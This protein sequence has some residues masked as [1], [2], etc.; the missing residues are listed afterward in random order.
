M[1]QL[2]IDIHAVHA[3][4]RLYEIAASAKALDATRGLEPARLDCRTS[5]RSQSRRA[6]SP[7]E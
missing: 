3:V 5:G 2:A 6:D 4:P 1:E 7:R